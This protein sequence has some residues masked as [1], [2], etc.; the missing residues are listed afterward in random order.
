MF[1]RTCKLSIFTIVLMGLVSSAVLVTPAEAVKK[2]IDKEL[3]K[4]VS[5]FVKDREAA[6]SGGDSKPRDEAEADWTVIT[7]RIDEL[8]LGETVKLATFGTSATVR[9]G[10]THFLY[11]GFE[12]QRKKHELTPP[13][14]KL[15]AGHKFLQEL[16]VKGT[17]YT[18]GET[19]PKKMRDLLA[20]NSGA[21]AL[22]R[23][24]LDA[25][26]EKMRKEF[27]K[28]YPLDVE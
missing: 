6:F 13:P 17:C 7:E 14:E 4:K 10:L 21:L 16:V 24:H 9:Q 2:R 18:R 11:I 25:W 12:A 23:L 5:R 3:M 8:Y 27:E 15:V 22:M 19:Y 1:S 28:T 20:V 26:D